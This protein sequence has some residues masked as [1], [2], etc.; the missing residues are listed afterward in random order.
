LK[1]RSLDGEIKNFQKAISGNRYEVGNLDAA[2]REIYQYADARVED[3]SLIWKETHE[4]WET[5]HRVLLEMR[6][7][8]APITS[9]DP[10]SIRTDKIEGGYLVSVMPRKFGP[11]I[12]S[13]ERT[14]FEDGT[15]NDSIAS[16]AGGGFYFASR[17]IAQQVA[18]TI[19]YLVHSCAK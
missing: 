14:I 19:V 15:G 18:K 13:H 3:C 1:Q 6:E 11:G 2:K 16:G 4:I 9:I 10:T 5:G 12:T 17:P 7:V 8:T